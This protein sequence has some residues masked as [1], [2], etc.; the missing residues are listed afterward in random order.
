MGTATLRLS[1]ADQLIRALAEAGTLP[2]ASAAAAATALLLLQRVPEAGGPP[3]VEVPMTL[4]NSRLTVVRVPLARVGAIA[5][6][7]RRGPEFT[8]GEDPTLPPRR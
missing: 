3:Q 4:E 2:P 7:P 5:W 1:G 6:P 8:P